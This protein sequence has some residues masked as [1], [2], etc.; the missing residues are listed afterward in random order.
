MPRHTLDIHLSALPETVADKYYPILGRFMH[1]FSAVETEL[2]SLLYKYI[3]HYLPWTHR[4]SPAVIRALLGEMRMNALRDNLKRILR[5]VQATKQLKHA[6]EHCLNQIG[7]IQSL[8]DLL[9]HKPALF[10]R[11]RTEEEWLGVSNTVTANEFE[12]IGVVYFQLE[13]LT[14]MTTDLHAVHTFIY[15]VLGN[16]HP[17]SYKGSALPA[18]RYKPS[19]LRHGGPKSVSNP[20]KQKPQQPSSRR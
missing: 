1:T 7:E 14:N 12:K 13:T 9:A 18:W 6:L 16:T 17:E 19:Q 3:S 10:D 5:V 2:H 8:R 15:K 20:P 11:L 4:E